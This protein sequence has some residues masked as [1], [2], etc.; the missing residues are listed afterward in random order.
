[1]CICIAQHLPAIVA[2][3]RAVAEIDV[4]AAKAKLGRVLN[5]II[6]QVSKLLFNIV[7]HHIQTPVWYCAVFGFIYY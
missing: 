2:A 6:P 1:M 5:G 7:Q 4:F 3:V